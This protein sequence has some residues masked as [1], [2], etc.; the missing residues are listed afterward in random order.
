MNWCEL[1]ILAGAS[2]LSD[3]SNVIYSSRYFSPP[4]SEERL[5]GDLSVSLVDGAELVVVHHHV[6]VIVH[7]QV[8]GARAA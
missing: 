4:V 3:V 1:T 2:S 8:R 6:L 7:D 5:L